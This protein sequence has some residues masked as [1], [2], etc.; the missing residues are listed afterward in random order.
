MYALVD[1]NSFYASC[2]QI[3]RPDLRNKPVVVLSNNDGCI[4]AR[5]KEAK[6]IGI[7]DLHAFFKVK[8]FLEKNNIA[9]FSANFSLYGDISWRVMETLRHFSPKTEVY[10]ID[11]MFVDLQGEQKDLKPLGREIKDRIYKHVRMP[12]GV[13]IAPTK[14]LAKLANRG[15]KKINQLNGVCVLDEPH[16]WEW[17]QQRLPVNKVWGVGSRYAKRLNRLG[18][19]TIYDLAQASPKQIRKHSNVCLE[20]AVEELNGTPC[21]E[22][23]DTNSPKKQ[24]YI[25]RSFGKKA[26][27]LEELENHISRYAS[28]A[29]EKLRAQNCKACVI[30]VFVQTSPFE[31]DYYGNARTIS[32]P[33]PTDDTRTLISHAKFLIGT[34]YK[35]NKRY[36]RCGVGI[37]DLVDNQFQQSDLFEPGQSIRSESLMRL[38]DKI[39]RRYGRDTAIFGSEGLRGKWTMRQEYLSP[40]YSTSWN[41]LPCISC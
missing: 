27:S 39:N 7:P 36:Q 25:T 26:T 35:E 15:A 22:L 38:V 2:E 12:V 32:L 28:A 3:F 10:S 24:I 19:Y 23:E 30:T 21:I 34:I 1:C 14:T 6:E 33:Y 13:G 18:I 4:I 40:R 31:D 11:E 29:A 41:D 37:I 17:L 8:P 20:R 16:K 5:S 9:I